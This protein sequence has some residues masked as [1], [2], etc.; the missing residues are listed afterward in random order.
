[1]PTAMAPSTPGEPARHGRHRVEGLAGLGRLERQRRDRRVPAL[2]EPVAGHTRSGP[3]PTSVD[4][5]GLPP[6]DHVLVRRPRAGLRLQLLA[7]QR[8]GQRDHAGEHRHDA[9]DRR[10]RTCAS[11]TSTGAA[12]SGVVDAVDRRPGP[13]GR[14]PLRVQDQRPAGSAR[15]RDRPRPPHHLRL[16]EGANTFVLRAIDSAGNASRLGPVHVDVHLWLSRCRPAPR[17]RRRRR[18]SPSPRARTRSRRR[19]A[20]PRGYRSLP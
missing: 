14:D 5:I 17:S 18:A 11:A 2:V 19:P 3:S 6:L 13:A 9:A 1:M 12:R 8:P 16:V 7:V 20:R 10:R 4:L 15:R